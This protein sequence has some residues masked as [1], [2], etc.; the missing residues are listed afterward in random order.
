MGANI[1][2][3]TEASSIGIRKKNIANFD[4]NEESMGKLFRCASRYLNQ[5]MK[6][7]CLQDELDRMS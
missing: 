1:D 5:E 7:A 6:I 3:Y 2:S 4:Q